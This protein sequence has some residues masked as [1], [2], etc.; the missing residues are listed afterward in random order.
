MSVFLRRFIEHKK[1]IM[2]AMITVFSCGLLFGF[3]QYHLS[4][5]MIKDYFSH[6][7]YLNVEGYE[8]QYQLY[9]IQGSLYIFI[10][11][12]LSTSYLGHFGLLFLLFLKGLQLSY[13]FIF[14][15]TTV[16]I[17]FLLFLFLV[18]ETILEISLCFAMNFICIHISIYTTLVTFFVEQN[19]SMK[20]MLN[21]KLN[22]IIIALVIFSL[23]LAFR[24]Y[25]IPM[26]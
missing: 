1:L 10:C 16:P 4:N 20:S 25:I 3:Y 2:I 5:Q 17:S 15:F 7:F 19:F 18:L 22:C 21:Y 8:N 24:I 14:V 26:F 9:V 12:Y 11:T 13:S 6:L 23:A